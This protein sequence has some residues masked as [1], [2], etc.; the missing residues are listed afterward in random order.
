MKETSGNW[1]GINNSLKIDYFRR[2]PHDQDC[3]KCRFECY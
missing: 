1:R 2:Q 3:N